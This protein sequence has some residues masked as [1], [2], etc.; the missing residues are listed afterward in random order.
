MSI[1]LAIETS[2]QE[3]SCALWVRDQWQE[4]WL[5]PAVPSSQSLL[6]AVQGLLADA[7]VTWSQLDGIAF[8]AGPGAFTGLRVACGVTQGLA[9]AHDLPVVGIE[10]LAALAWS[11]F[12]ENVTATECLTA[13]DARM[14]E[15]YYAR[16]Q[17]TGASLR[18]M[19]EIRVAPPA[20][21][22]VPE[23]GWIAGNAQRAY[24]AFAT[25]VAHLS[26]FP[27]S[28]H[29]CCIP[30]AQAIGILGQQAFERGEG[31]AA[32]TALPIYVR[33]KVA[34]TVAERLAQGGKA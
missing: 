31:G 22:E 30:S 28:L 9:V 19:G 6:P 20:A 5:D 11:A 16:Y 15:I 23:Q 10:T 2:T 14:N 21:V 34:Q 29:A 33:D 27:E 26:S 24:P 7:G 32:E 12:N 4:I 17:R 18:R 1:V 3:S 8:G 25:R 13:L